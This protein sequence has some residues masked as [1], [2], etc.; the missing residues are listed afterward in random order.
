[1]TFNPLIFLPF[2]LLNLL[3]ES[4][5]KEEAQLPEIGICNG[6]E[7]AEAYKNVGISFLEEGVG[8][9]LLPNQDV[10]V[11]RKKK[12]N[13]D[14]LPLPVRSAL[15]F[16]PGNL[17]SVGPELNVLKILA[18]AETVFKRA[19]ETGIAYVVFGSGVSRNIPE[20]FEYETARTQFIELNK[21]L[22]P[23]AARYNVILVLEALNRKECNFILSLAEAG[24]IVE[25]VDHPN[26]GLLADIYH[27]MMEK[28][29]P[30][31]IEIY[32]YLIKHVH[33]AE[34]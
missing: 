13:I 29:G 30:Q 7:L 33:V 8:T 27:M 16:L 1:M 32:G 15:Y 26:F 4:K 24:A 9:V 10:N 22:A 3:G 18:F 23:L 25:Q 31:S 34:L 12:S 19:N 21:Q 11:F 5:Q 14:V 17:K 6:M 2:F 20:G 28:E